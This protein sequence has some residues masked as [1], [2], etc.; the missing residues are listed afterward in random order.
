[1]LSKLKF[2]G[3][4]EFFSKHCIEKIY[5]SLRLRRGRIN[6]FLF[7]KY[8]I[9]LGYMYGVLLIEAQIYFKTVKCGEVKNIHV[10]RKCKLNYRYL[11]E[12]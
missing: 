7:V 3:I 11:F 5:T 10:D 9:K 8:I 12:T 2:H 6:L 4:D 1:M